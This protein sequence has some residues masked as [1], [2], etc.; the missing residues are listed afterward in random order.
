MA[1]RRGLDGAAR[2]ATAIEDLGP[3][4]FGGSLACFGDILGGRV[5]NYHELVEVHAFSKHLI[6]LF[7]DGVSVHVWR[8]MGLTLGVPGLAIAGASKVVLEVMPFGEH[9][10]GT[11]TRS[12]EYLVT[13]SGK[14]EIRTNGNTIGPR[15]W[16]FG[17]KKRQQ[18]A[19]GP[20]R[21]HVTLGAPAFEI[22][23]HVEYF[24]PT[25]A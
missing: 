18:V 3:R 14:V 11:E 8:P 16:P 25:D 1:R 19:P 20:D 4:S 24:T 17:R 13:D 12:T 7:E 23:D 9:G 21:A 5:D 15:F 2:I 6:L 22:I 10:E